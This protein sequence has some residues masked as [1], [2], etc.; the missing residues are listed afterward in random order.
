MK[1]NPRN[2]MVYGPRVIA[3]FV[4]FYFA[5]CIAVYFAFRWLEELGQPT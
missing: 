2:P 1:Y 3:F 5:A 4:L